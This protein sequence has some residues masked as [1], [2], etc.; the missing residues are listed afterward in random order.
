[1]ASLRNDT[2]TRILFALMLSMALVAMDTTIVATAIPQV[3]G[4]LGGFSLVGWV[5]SVYLLAQTVTIPVYGKLA[6]LYGRKPILVIGIVVFLIGSALSALAWSMVTLILFR[7]LQG[8]G[9]G[10]IGATVNTVAGDLYDVRERGRVQGWLSSVWGVSA[11]VAP[12]LGGAFAEYASWRWI[13]LVNL[14]I[15]AFALTMI[16]R[17][18]HEV[19]E[20][21]A[22]R[23]DYAGAGLL[24]AAAGLLIFGLLQGGTSWPWLSVPSVL[25]FAGS[26]FA[27]VS[28]VLVERRASEPVLPPWLWSRRQIAGSY[29]ATGVS[30]LLIIGLSTFL[31]TW[32]QAVLGLG[33]VAAGFMLAV[34]SMTWPLFSGLSS[35]FYLRIGFRDTALVGSVFT[36]AAGVV[37]VLAPESAPV[38]QPVLGSALMGAGLGLITSSLIVGLQSTVGWSQRGVITGGAIFSRFLGQSIGAAVFGAITNTVLLHRIENAPAGLKQQ[39]PGSVDGMSRALEG[40]HASAGA[41]AYM[42]AALQASTHAV[43][44]GLLLASIAALLLLGI[45]PR[46]FTTYE[47]GSEAELETPAG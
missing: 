21:R 23:I 32:G 26:A 25:I 41:E 34:M 45:V 5:F 28:V 47:V 40:H 33:A 8:L 24:F 19:V 39:I 10:S 44:L 4:D 17:E 31:P 29:A 16:V 1:M 9:A 38:W 18:L 37:F 7:A 12:A 46:H 35:R 43:F 2:R 30:G 22:H 14:P 20:R 36:I 6:D 15:G 11:V 27:T 13:F 42:R 3:V